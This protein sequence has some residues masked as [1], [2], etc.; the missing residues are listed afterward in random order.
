MNASRP[1]DNNGYGCGHSNG[2]R[3]WLVEES[4]ADADEANG[5]SDSRVC[6]FDIPPCRVLVRILECHCNAVVT[7]HHHPHFRGDEGGG[8]SA[9][10]IIMEEY[11]APGQYV[12]FYT[13][14]GLCVGAG[15][16]AN[17]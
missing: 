9:S 5:T 4:S 7:A 15:V 12:A 2:G 14:D 6:D 11:V 17:G 3:S 8:I 10:A 13:D 16:A 1:A